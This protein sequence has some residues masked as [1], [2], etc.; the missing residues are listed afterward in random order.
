MIEYLVLISFIGFVAFLIPGRHSKYAAIL[1]WTSIVLFLFT[2]LPA[3]FSQNN[4]MYPLMAVLSVPFLVITVRC[5]LREDPIALRL[6]TTAAVAAIIFVPFSL[7]PFLRDG[8]ITVTITLAFSLITALGHHPAM[9]AWDVMME[10][11]FYCQIIPA[12][13]GILAIALMTGVIAGVEGLSFRQCFGM[14][15][16]VIPL[17]FFLNL[18]RVSVVFIAV[19]D[20][21]FAGFPDPTGTGDA[22]FFWAHN[23]IAEGLGVI[24]LVLLLIWLSRKTPALGGYAWDVVGMYRDGIKRLFG[25]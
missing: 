11:G 7:D 18:L 21:W 4:F 19:S 6:S 24:F 13:T 3:Y 12:C 25:R 16:D 2:E 1:G 17:I 9:Y 22:N 15:L 8:I 14:L 10:N 23:V 20:T 5:L